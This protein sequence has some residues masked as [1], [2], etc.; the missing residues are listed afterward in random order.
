MSK[1]LAFGKTS[2]DWSCGAF[3]FTSPAADRERWGDALAERE[4]GPL[5]ELVKAEIFRN[6]QRILLLQTSGKI[7]TADRKTY[8]HFVARWQDFYRPRAGKFAGEDYITLIN[9]RDENRRYAANLTQLE[10]A[11]APTSPT[12]SPANEV[13]KAEQTGLQLVRRSLLAVVGAVL[14]ARFYKNKKHS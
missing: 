7:S 5:S 13:P 2:R 1:D 10:K 11:P 12:T 14:L 9:F 8:G 4:V 3:P 6:F